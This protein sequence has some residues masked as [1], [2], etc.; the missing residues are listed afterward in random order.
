MYRF[1]IVG[2]SS[3][4]LVNNLYKILTSQIANTRFYRNRVRGFR[5]EL[6]FSKKTRKKKISTLEP[7]QFLFSNLKRR[8]Q[9][10]NHI[11]YVTV[12]S[13][14]KTRYVNF[15][16]T[17]K[18]LDEVEKLFFIEIGPSSSWEQK[19]IIV[20]NVKKKKIDDI[21][22]K[23]F[24]T[25]FEF[26]GSKWKSSNFD[27]IKKMLV[28]RNPRICAKKSSSGFK[29]L[30]NYTKNELIPI[31]CSRYFLDIELID[32]N[33]GMIDF[34]HILKKGNNFTLVE[35]K[36]KDPMKDKKHPKNKKLWAFGW[37]SRRFAWYYHLKHELDLNSWYVIREV[38]NQ[39]QR[40]LVGW[41]K[42]DFEKFCKCASWLAE[43][44][45]G[46][47]GGTISAPY[48]AFDVLVLH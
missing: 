21:I 15:Y 39:T 46:G 2:I 42:I 17:I 12:S 5:S 3:E 7:G 35:T 37:D 45:G 4:T 25:V 34:D 26:A 28:K 8:Q 1:Q 44:A 43:R 30:K 48:T 19:K 47:G 14:N 32:Y 13:D 23:P 41:R 40:K 22:P 38:N 27:A 10:E 9:P 33:K 16:K 20:K 24:F 31:Y 11:I 29:Y 36:E 18:K 6:E